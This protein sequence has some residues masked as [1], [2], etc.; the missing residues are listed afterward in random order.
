[1]SAAVAVPLA[2]AAPGAQ[3]VPPVELRAVACRTAFGDARTT[4]ERLLRG[5]R[6]LRFTPVRQEDGET[7]AD[8]VPLALL[9]DW[10]PDATR[11]GG[12]PRWEE[13][14]F[15]LLAEVPDRPWGTP[16]FPIFVTSSNFGI[17][18]LYAYSRD[19]H[20]G[21]LG[22][23]LADQLT[24]T[25][26][27]RLG[28]GPNV[29][30]LSHACV[31]SNLGLLYASRQVAA[32]MAEEA[33]IVSYDFLSPFVTAGFHA[34]K[35]LFGEMPAPYAEREFGAIGLGDGAAFATL[36]PVSGRGPGGGG[37]GFRLEAQTGNNEMYH[38]T[39]NHPEGVGM[40]DLG[41]HMR[42]AADARGLRVWVKG[43]GTG[44]IEAGRLEARH[45]ARAFPDAPLVGW[46][47]AL[48]HTLGS[49]GLVE[50]ALACE[51]VRGGRAAGTV[52]ST[53][54]A[55]FAPTVATEPFSTAEFSGV[56]L[57]SFAFGGAHYAFLL[58]HD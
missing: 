3:A 58:G 15:G 48:G 24:T 41:E 46:K 49:C 34:L 21:R 9:N 38:F 47:G 51:F 57:N 4:A 17:G 45:M 1:M 29:S 42:R 13:P 32:G 7:V 5:E 23:F 11:T 30:H 14:L 27:E 37:T 33:L 20:P 31:S 16:R 52:G 10:D 39:G 55:C 35:I 56:V 43:H 40:A 50:L 22:F 44:T 2:E 36:G 6:A 26:R 25:L 19:Q 12:R 54:Q 18:E 8:P 53:G 28:W